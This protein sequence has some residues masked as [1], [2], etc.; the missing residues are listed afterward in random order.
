MRTFDVVSQITE[1][2]SQPYNDSKITLEVIC[3]TL[4]STVTLAQ[5][6]GN[7]NNFTKMSPILDTQSG[8]AISDVLTNGNYIM[9][10]SL[11]AFFLGL[12]LNPDSATTGTVTIIGRV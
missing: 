10:S 4:D 2:N 11:R 9:Y 6:Q 8:L 5:F 7:Q 12:Q 3:A 1:L